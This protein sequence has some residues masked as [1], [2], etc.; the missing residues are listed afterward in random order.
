MATRFNR[1][2]RAGVLHYLTL[3]VRER[4]RP[5]VRDCYARVLLEILREHCD[6][7]PARLVAY[8]VQ[9][10]HF[11]G[12]VNPRDGDI[13]TFVRQY[14][15]DVTK[16]VAQ[17]AADLQHTSVLKWL[18]A[19]STGRP[20]FWQDGKYNF[21]LWSERLIHQKMDYI[22]RN[23]VK[24]G[25][26]QHAA[27]YLYTSF[28]AIHHLEGEIIVPVDAAWWWEDPELLPDLLAIP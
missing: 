19:T 5:F 15:A 28:R 26:V 17:I 23:P 13:I 10:D 24:L 3:N 11:H 16:A 27:E 12:I 1:G 22:H 9:L 14:K 21:H 6:R 8:G 18:Y 4:R 7:H 20:Q 2:N 25:F